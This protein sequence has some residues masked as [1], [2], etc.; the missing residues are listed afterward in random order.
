VCISLT[1]YIQ[2]DMKKKWNM[3]FAVNSES[4]DLLF[5]MIYLF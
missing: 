4:T 2:L 3:N 5:V 1:D